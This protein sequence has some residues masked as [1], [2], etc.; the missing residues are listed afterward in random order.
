M[1]AVSNNHS[2]MAGLA[3]LGVATAFG[4]I[5]VSM[6]QTCGA[7]IIEGQRQRIDITKAL[8]EGTEVPEL[9]IDDNQMALL[10]AGRS[11]ALVC[12]FG[13]FFMVTASPLVSKK[14]IFPMRSFT[15]LLAFLSFLAFSLQIYLMRSIK[16]GIT[17]GDR[18]MRISLAVIYMVFMTVSL[19]VM[20]NY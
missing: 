2:C 19:F 12:L 15:F 6:E 16:M 3:N 17:R 4:A 8:K 9:E 18:T 14:R 20:F 1:N 5:M 11:F 10:Q 7:F 13:I